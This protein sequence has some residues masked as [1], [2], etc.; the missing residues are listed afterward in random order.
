MSKQMPLPTKAT[1]AAAMLPRQRSTT[2][3][4]GLVAA[5]ADRQQPA[6]A[7]PRQPVGVPAPSTAMPCSASASSRAAKV[8]RGQRIGRLRR[9]VAGQQAARAPPA[10]ARAQCG[11]TAAGSSTTRSSACSPRLFPAP[12]AGEAPGAQAGAGGQPG[13]G[14]RR[15][16]PRIERQPHRIAGRGRGAAAGPLPV[17][18]LPRR[19]AADQQHAA[20]RQRHRHDLPGPSGEA[21]RGGGG[22]QRR[23]HRRRIRQR[24]GAGLPGGLARGAAELDLQHRARVQPS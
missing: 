15:Q 7:L 8:A 2:S 10:E 13:G 9:Q 14:V 16:A 1:G 6:A 22:P 18:R 11:A 4:G 20:R 5:L 21:G 3:R 19:A 12:G 24:Q 23:R 17:Q